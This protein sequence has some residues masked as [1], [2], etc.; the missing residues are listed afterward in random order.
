MQLDYSVSQDQDFFPSALQ[1]NDEI[2]EGLDQALLI[3]NRLSYLVALG[4]EDL[5]VR[6]A[7]RR[8]HL[9]QS[10]SDG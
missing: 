7:R 6:A 10:D 2:R 4:D 8:I 1:R 5:R 9:V 3:L